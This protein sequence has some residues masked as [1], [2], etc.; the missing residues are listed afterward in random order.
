MKKNNFKIVIFLFGAMISLL[1][2]GKVSSQIDGYNEPVNKSFGQLILT[3][4]LLSDFHIKPD[5]FIKGL[6]FELSVEVLSYLSQEDL[7]KLFLGNLHSIKNNYSYEMNWRWPFVRTIYHHSELNKTWMRLISEKM[8]QSQIYFNL[9][10]FKFK[11]KPRKVEL[12]E[13]IDLPKE[14][15]VIRA[16]FDEPEN[17]LCHGIFPYERK[18]DEVDMKRFIN[19]N[20]RKMIVMI[21]PIIFNPIH[22]SR[23]VAIYDICLNSKVIKKIKDLDIITNSQ[24]TY[25][26]G[27]FCL[28]ENDFENSTPQ[29]LMAFVESNNKTIRF[30]NF[31]NL[32][33]KFKLENQDDILNIVLSKNPT[34]QN[35]LAVHLFNGDIIIYSVPQ[36]QKT[37]TIRNFK[38]HIN[39][40]G[41]FSKDLRFLLAT[42]HYSEILIIELKNNPTFIFKKIEVDDLEKALFLSD[43]TIA[44]TTNHSEMV[45]FLHPFGELESDLMKKIKKTKDQ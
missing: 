37:L 31:K 10:K 24:L 28:E 15:G 35:Y 43:S 27:S 1:F 23:N 38:G 45:N 11:V 17:N 40:I 41:N 12:V 7:K 14:S 3:P 20:E 39:S 21:D 5:G 30:F 2:V 9:S 34:P 19:L 22:N 4:S 16:R 29:T 32:E 44:Y 13:L 33:E 18:N 8:R 36:L 42:T 25:S 26:E 6:P